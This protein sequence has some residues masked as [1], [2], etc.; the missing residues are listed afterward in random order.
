MLNADADYAR[1]VA[2]LTKQQLAPYVS[3]AKSDTVKG[4]G[5]HDASG[6]VVVRVSDGVIISGDSSGIEAG[7]YH[8]RANPVT[9]SSFEAACYHAVSESEASYNGQP[10]IKLTLAPT[11]KSSNPNDVE[12]PFTTLY[13]DSQTLRPLDVS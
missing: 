9:H 4:F 10:A 7:N 5:K 13:A 1:I 12:Y 8:N 6:R 11:C 3:Y 2:L